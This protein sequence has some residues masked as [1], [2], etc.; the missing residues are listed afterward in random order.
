MGN[1]EQACFVTGIGTGVGKT[2]VSAVLCS[3]LKSL[4]WKPVQAGRDPESDTE[5]VKRL[6]ALGDEHFLPEF[7]ILQTPCSPHEA[8]KIEGIRLNPDEIHLPTPVG[9]FLLVEGAGGIF[10]PLNDETLYISLVKR[11]NIPV[12]VVSANYLG[13]INHSLLTLAAIKDQQ[14]PIKGIIF[15]GVANPESERV[16]ESYSGC[17]VLGKIPF[18]ANPDVVAVQSAFQKYIS[19]E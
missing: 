9:K 2:F 3:G 4:Y 18:I 15:S 16:I 14:I 7:K 19:W 13:S 12:V 1:L 8:A 5:T 10:V 6:T 17:K 11:W